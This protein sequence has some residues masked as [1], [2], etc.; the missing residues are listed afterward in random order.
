MGTGKDELSTGH[1]AR[2]HPLLIVLCK[3]VCMSLQA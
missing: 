3:V 2:L 1:L